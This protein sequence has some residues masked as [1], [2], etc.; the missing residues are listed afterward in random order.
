MSLIKR[1]N[2]F[3]I[4]HNKK[5]VFLSWQKKAGA[6]I[7]SIK[8]SNDGFNF[9]P[10]RKKP[11]IAAKTKAK[12][13]INK[14]QNFYIAKLG[15]KYFLT[16]EKA[17][18]G[19]AKVFGATSLNLSKWTVLGALSGIKHSGAVVPDFFYDDERIMYTGKKNI[20]IAYSKDLKKWREEKKIV[21][22]TRS[23][24]FD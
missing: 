5:V 9:Y 17:A 23:S 12:E 19:A 14:C 13:N 21:L 2:L 16:Y 15:E 4:N 1:K 24:K 22:K 6:S 8:E 7:L 18:W 10:S 20:N 3:F 11:I